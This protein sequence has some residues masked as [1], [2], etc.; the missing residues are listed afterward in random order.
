M[1]FCIR[2]GHSTP[3]YKSQTQS[4]DFLPLIPGGIK[5][6]TQKPEKGIYLRKNKTHQ[7][8]KIKRQKLVIAIVTLAV[9][10]FIAGCIDEKTP[11]AENPISIPSLASTASADPKLAL[12]SSYELK[13][14]SVTA[15][16]P[17]YQLPLN[18]NDISN[19]N[20]INSY[21]NLEEGVKGKLESNGFV[22]IPWH[23]DDIIQPYKTMKDGEIP[24]FVSSDTLLHLYHIQFNEILKD[25]EEEEAAGYD[26]SAAGKVE[27]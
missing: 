10:L 7:Q 12:A 20:K 26:K 25:I 27:G 17:Q 19:I 13:G 15:N 4:T 11:P 23:G 3:F 5:D 21:F 24:I 16:A 2:L 18:L 6:P 9:I 14:F 8:M 1:W 22:I